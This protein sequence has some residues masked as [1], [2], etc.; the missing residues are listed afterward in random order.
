MTIC[1]RVHN[2]SQRVQHYFLGVNVKPVVIHHQYPRVVALRV[3]L[4]YIGLLRVLLALGLDEVASG[5]ECRR[6]F[7]IVRGLGRLGD[8]FIVEEVDFYL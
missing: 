6:A 7:S 4:P 5:G 3:V 2:I 1:R 8:V